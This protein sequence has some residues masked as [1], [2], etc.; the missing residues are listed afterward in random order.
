VE[1]FDLWNDPRDHSKGYK[2]D[3]TGEDWYHSGYEHNPW[4]VAPGTGGRL[5][6][7]DHA[8]F[9]ITNGVGV[10]ASILPVGGGAGHGTQHLR[11]VNREPSKWAGLAQ[12]GKFFRKGETYQFRG[13]FRSTGKPVKAEVRFYATG[14]WTK[15]VAV[16]PLKDF[17]SDWSERA[18]EFKN[19]SHSGWTTFALMLPP[20]TEVLV[21][22]FSLLPRKNFHGWRTDIIEPLKQI[23]PT[24]LRVPGG[25]FASFYDWRDGVGPMSERKPKPSY[26]WGGQNYNDVG[27]AE[28]ALLAKAIGAETMYCVNVFHPL[29]PDYEWYFGEDSVPP[30]RHGYD[31]QNFRDVKQGAK[32]AAELVAYCNLPAGKHPLADLRVKHGFRE[33]FGI[34]YWELD[35][36]VHRW[37]EPEEYAEAAVE[38][39]K[40]MKAVDPTIQIGLVTYG[41]R[42]KADGKPRVTYH[43]RVP[44]MLEIAGRHIDFLADRGPSEKGYLAQMIGWMNDYN[45]RHGTKILYCETEKLFYEQ[46]PD[47]ENRI[48]PTDGYSKSFMFSK[49]FYAQKAMMDY[50]AY[51]RA[52]GD[53]N[54]VIF[55]NLANTHSQCV[56]DT[57]KEGVFITAAGVGM[58]QLAH[59]AAAWPL[60]FDGYEANYDDNFQVSAAWD[61]ERKKLVLYI[62]NR[63]AQPRDVTFSIASLGRAFNRAQSTAL[64]A[65]DSFVMNTL[66][67][68]DAIK[69]EVS[70]ATK[71]SKPGEYGLSARPWS[72]TEVVVE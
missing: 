20:G 9:I 42:L 36:E 60:R 61:R 55:N 16:L 39:S 22:D 12:E 29:K 44:A 41:E 54:F 67:N 43:E 11:V 19:G 26:F 3:W 37:F 50:M 52:G 25:C 46:F 15:P 23:R 14:D 5:P 40:A 51:Q 58:G 45:A 24:I 38:Y 31:F 4:F 70:A 17:G 53:I 56:I 59:S 71:L 21:D 72:F 62:L 32:E 64:W 10:N 49:W 33:P 57:P 34:K 7:D 2:T 30:G 48:K 13:K 66:A 35:N 47:V 65:H 69:R 63:T 28:L 1:W 18:V 6:I 27:V 68:P 8:T